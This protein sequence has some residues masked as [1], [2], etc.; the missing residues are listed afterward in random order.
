MTE[1]KFKKRDR[2]RVRNESKH[3]PYRGCVGVVE[4]VYPRLDD[5]IATYDVLL[6]NDDPENGPVSYMQDELEDAGEK[7]TWCRLELARDCGRKDPHVHLSLQSPGAVSFNPKCGRITL[8]MFFVDLNPRE[9][10]RT[11]AAFENPKKADELAAGCMGV[12]QADQIARF[13][14]DHPDPVIVNCEA[15][16]S[17]SPAVVLALREWYGGSV[18]DVMKY[19]V[20][21]M[22]VAFTLAHVLRYRKTVRKGESDD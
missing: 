2:I 9:I 19:S 18:W 10:K 6:D 12:D 1:P 8:S 3:T 14:E 4:E 15:G 13:V 21:N 16:I 11:K 17:R 22:H 7:Y 20:P 5:D